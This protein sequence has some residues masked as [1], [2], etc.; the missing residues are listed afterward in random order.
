MPK[1]AILSYRNKGLREIR[2]A[3]QYRFTVILVGPSI[4]GVGFAGVESKGA[5]SMSAVPT[6]LRMHGWGCFPN[7]EALG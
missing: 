7:A 5:G 6:G 1:I 2:G 4:S 3:L